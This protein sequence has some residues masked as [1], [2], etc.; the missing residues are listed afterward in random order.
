MDE[1][2]A[3]YPA[4]SQE[5]PTNHAARILVIGYIFLPIAILILMIRLA[6]RFKIQ[7]KVSIDDW[8]VIAATVRAQ[9]CEIT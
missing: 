1:T 9:A 6:W 7:K 2:T 8:F 5:S 3:P 4:F